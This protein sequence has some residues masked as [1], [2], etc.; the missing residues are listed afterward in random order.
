MLTLEFRQKK[1]TELEFFAIIKV[2][3]GIL[4]TKS[5]ISYIISVKQ[6]GWIDQIL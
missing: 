3:S 2:Y 1:Y 5:V 6:A 4:K